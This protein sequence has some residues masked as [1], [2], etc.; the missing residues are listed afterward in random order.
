MNNL[1]HKLS[2][3]LLEK[4]AERAIPEL[5][6]RE[7]LSNPDQIVDDKTGEKGQKVFQSIINFTEN[8]TYLV[9]VFVNT[10]FSD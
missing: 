1:E 2:K 7:I 6:I 4:A 3:H 8:S 9:R 10:L 5:M